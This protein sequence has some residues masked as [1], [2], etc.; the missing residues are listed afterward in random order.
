M[1]PIPETAAGIAFGRF[2]VFPHRRELLA[3]GQPL[4]LG[5]RAYDVLMA[6]IEARGNVVSKDALMARVWPNRVVEE[7]ALQAQISALRTAFG[8]ERELIR[9]VS[10]RGYQ[11]A[12]EI[13]IPCGVQDERE[14]PATV[15]VEPGS[16]TSRTNLPEQV[17]ELIGRE[18][19][20]CQ[21][22]SLATSHRLLT[23]TGT[24]GIGKTRLALAVAHMLVA[25]FADGVW[26]A[27]LAPLPNSG[28]VP[29]VVA[30]ATGVELGP[31][32]CSAELVAKALSA[33]K[34]LLVLDNCEHV[35]D[36][37]ATMVEAL[38]RAAPAL[39]LIATSREPLKAEGE[40]V[41]QVQPLGTPTEHAEH[42]DDPLRYGAVQLF[43]ER[44]RAGAP[45]FAPGQRQTAMVG[46]ICRRLDGIPLAIELAAARVPALGVEELAMRIDDCFQLLTGGR[47]TALPR[48]RTLRATLDW[49]YDLLSEDEK[50][51]FRRVG[52]FASNFDLKAATGIASDAHLA[53]GA[54]V[55]HLSG[56]VTKS[57]VAAYLDTPI[58]RFRLVETTRA[59]ALEKLAASGEG[60]RL[61]RR[62]AEYARDRLERAQPTLEQRPTAD[63]L[64][65]YRYWVDNLRWALDWAFSAE[66]DASV[67][68]A[69]TAAAVPLWMHLSLVEECRGWVE[70]ALGALAA[71]ASPDARLEMR[72]C[73]AQ[74]ALLVMAR[75]AGDPASG[76]AWTKALAFAERLDDVEYQ[77]RALWGLWLFHINSG[78]YR[79][80]LNLAERFLDLAAK[81]PA[82]N[83]PLFGQRMIGVSLYLR[84][85]MTAARHHLE[86]VLAEYVASDDRSHT[87]RFQFDLL[88]S[89]R[90]Y[91]AWIAWLQGLPDQAIRVTE[92][93]VEDARTAN[94]ALSLCFALALAACPIAFLVGDL[95]A[96]EQYVSMLVGQSSRYGL[97]LWSALGRAYQGLL[98]IKQGDVAAGI[99][100]LRTG[101]NDAGAAG[102]AL[103]LITCLLWSTKPS[104]RGSQAAD[105]LSALEDAIDRCHA[106]EEYWPIAE[107]LRAKGELLLMQDGPSAVAMA[108]EQFRQALGWA[109]RQ[110][111]LSWELRAATSLARLLGD[112]GRSADAKLIL[113]PVYDRFTE[114]FGTADLKT[115]RVLLDAVR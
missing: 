65:T 109:R 28:L 37:A 54:V 96:A 59:Y 74:G 8:A 88:V 21:A 36:A 89:D 51:L 34:I 58:P 102:L 91:I 5:G 24:G 57:L 76:A 35:I 53:P 55:E 46:T 71:S 7:N 105:Q 94:H 25:H 69:L 12:G 103:R 31:G 32:T 107:L 23:L 62:A 108:E 16:A 20:L 52:V 115:A 6:L 73:A 92:N 80:P 67:G 68:V 61:A 64:V 17:S 15:V 114:G 38:L 1:D 98:L 84:G 47:R 40:Q 39:H 13:R 95:T 29:A 100:L 42:D 97:A 41:Y 11:F 77:L 14:D 112:N 82:T 81:R 72:L 45:R 10:G 60:E 63:R 44:T 78:L 104:C 70:Q 30:T 111:A 50:L 48:H 56:L 106:T 66:G 3:D 110:E 18:E 9:T 27:E 87:I 85:N 4:N 79:V 86:R 2:E 83:D 101:L 43:L 113:R 22:V 33:R 93:A 19:E 49:S 75:G 26:L 90:V 99:A